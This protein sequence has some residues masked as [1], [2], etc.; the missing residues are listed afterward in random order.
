MSCWRACRDRRDPEGRQDQRSWSMRAAANRSRSYAVLDFESET[1]SC[2]RRLVRCAGSSY[3]AAADAGRHLQRMLCSGRELRC[4]RIRRE[5]SCSGDRWRSGRTG[6]PGGPAGPGEPRGP[7]WTPSRA[8]S[9]AW[10]L[11][12]RRIRADVVFDL[13]IEAPARLPLRCGVARDIAARLGCRCSCLSRSSRSRAGLGYASVE[14]QRRS[15][16]SAH[17]QSAARRDQCG[18]PAVVGRRLT[19]R[20]AT[21]RL[22]RRRVELRHARVG[23]ADP[24]PTTIDRSRRP[25]LRVRAARPG[26][27]SSPLTE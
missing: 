11:P 23:S 7:G 5:S 27:R 1:W 4:R 16:S 24:S 14:V 13:A 20:D 8:G 6:G 9:T 15:W 17:G 26:R 19:W 3:R 18:S 10:R 12:G 22:D 2:S 21:D 25:W